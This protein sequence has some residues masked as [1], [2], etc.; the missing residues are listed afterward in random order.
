MVHYSTTTM[1]RWDRWD[2]TAEYFN[3]SDSLF[4][5]AWKSAKFDWGC[6]PIEIVDYLTAPFEI[7]AKFLYYLAAGP[8]LY[9]VDESS[10]L[11]LCRKLV[12]K[13]EGLEARIN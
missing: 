5:F 11:C 3:D 12:K 9:K 10:E 6:R 4:K 8:F 1:L 2:N 7:S 13:P